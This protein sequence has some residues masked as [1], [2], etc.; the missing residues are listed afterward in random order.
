MSICF[1][2]AEWAADER[3][4]MSALPTILPTI[5]YSAACSASSCALSSQTTWPMTVASP[6]SSNCANS[7]YPLRGRRV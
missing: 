1:F 3:V 2:T 6:V 5:G 4:I 7:A